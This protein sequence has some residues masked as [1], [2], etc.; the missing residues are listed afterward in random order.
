MAKRDSV[1]LPAATMSLQE[2]EEKMGVYAKADARISKIQ[3]QIDLEMTKIRDKYAEEL[4]SLG[5]ER[6]GAKEVLMLYCSQNKDK[7]ETKRSIELSHGKMGFRTGTPALKNKKGFTWAA[8][9]ELAKESYPQYV[10][11]KE[12][13]AKDAIL[14]DRELPEAQEIMSKLHVE[15][16]QDESWF[17][18]L[19]KEDAADQA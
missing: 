6:D 16:V 19:K 3:A 2:A 14:V 11:T 10:R 12:E 9:L 1:K 7:F 8:V 4:A 18:E 13:L 5:Q 17:I 15:V